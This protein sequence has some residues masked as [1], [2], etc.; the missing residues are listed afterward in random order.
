MSLLHTLHPCTEIRGDLS[1]HPFFYHESLV[2]IERA[3]KT[4]SYSGVT[5]TTLLE[6]EGYQIT[7]SWTIPQNQVLSSKYLLTTAPARNYASGVSG[8]WWPPAL[9]GLT[10]GS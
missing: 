3:S 9:T 7:P 8:S 1:R 4:V 6:I 10:R 5:K 2:Y